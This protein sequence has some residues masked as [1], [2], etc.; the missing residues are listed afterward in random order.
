MR[1]FLIVVFKKTLNLVTGYMNY[2]LLYDISLSKDN[3]G[4]NDCET[5]T[6]KEVLDTEINSI[7]G[8]SGYVPLVDLSP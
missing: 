6:E 3:S 7:S 4:S 8:M 1:I 5:I 2:F